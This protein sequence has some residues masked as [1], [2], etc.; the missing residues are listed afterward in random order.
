MNIE[1]LD[2]TQKQKTLAIGAI[3]VLILLVGF[4]WYFTR[5]SV[6]THTDT[7]EQACSKKTIESVE[8][9]TN[10][11]SCFSTKISACQTPTYPTMEAC[12]K[13]NPAVK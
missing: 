11:L 10:S 3:V 9:D 5:G 2:L 8:F 12:Q 1:R 13:A 7:R 6:Q 4:I